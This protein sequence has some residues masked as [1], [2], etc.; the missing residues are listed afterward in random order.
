MEPGATRGDAT[1][2]SIARQDLSNM[3]D[4]VFFEGPE[5]NRRLSR[6]WLLMP[7]SAVIAAAGIVSDST[8]TVIG[9]MIVAPLMVPIQGTMLSVVLGD[10][11][12]LIRSVGLVVAGAAAAIA[13]GW[14]LGAIVPGPVDAQNNAQVAARVNP[15]LIDLLAA[16]ATGAVGSIALVRR[17]ISD[18]LPG[19]AIAISL[20]PPLAVVG[21]TLQARQW[22]QAQGAMLLFVTNVAAILGV[23]TIVMALYRVQRMSP[24][25]GTAEERALN[26]RHAIVVIA[27]LAVIVV[28]PLTASSVT[29]AAQ[30]T[31]EIAVT[32]AADS[33]VRGSDWQVLSVVTGNN[34]RTVVEF[35]GSLPH[36]DPTVLRRSLV[37][38]NVD[39]STVTAQ[40]IPR[41]SVNLGTVPTAAGTG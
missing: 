27:I 17:D 32:A 4:S 13:I 39:P 10:R 6:F 11:R 14:V 2:P 1:V 20:V 26:R 31:S 21:L 36:P 23:G 19:V 41:E 18:T 28:V 24:Q 30:T 5:V 3:R 33:W 16:L 25:V 40:F 37:A 7:L 15:H 38:H 35:A 29:I 22:S 12:N 34:G 9:A 8:A